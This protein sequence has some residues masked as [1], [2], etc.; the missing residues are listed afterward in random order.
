[1][2]KTE[3]LIGCPRFYMTLSRCPEIA[4]ILEKKLIVTKKVAVKK[5]INEFIPRNVSICL[6]QLLFCG[7]LSAGYITGWSFPGGSSCRKPAALQ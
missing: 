6:M 3:Y 1:M 2:G 5:K 4:I 7:W